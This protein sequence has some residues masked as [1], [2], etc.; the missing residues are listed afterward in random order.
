MIYRDGLS[1]GQFSYAREFEVK[2]VKESFQEIDPNYW[3]VATQVLY[4]SLVPL[5]Y[6]L[7]WNMTILSR[8]AVPN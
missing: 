4:V 1:Y 8:C 5:N 3:Y 6:L 2:L 7:Y